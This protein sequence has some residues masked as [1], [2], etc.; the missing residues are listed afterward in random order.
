MRHGRKD[1]CP[2]PGPR[3]SLSLCEQGRRVRKQRRL[4]PAVDKCR[5][6]RFARRNLG[7]LQVPSAT[8][9]FNDRHSL[10]TAQRERHANRSFAVPNS[11]FSGPAGIVSRFREALIRARSRLFALWTRAAVTTMRLI[12]GRSWRAPQS[13]L[14]S[15]W[16]SSQ[17]YPD[18]GC[19]RSP[20]SF[21]EIR[22]TSGDTFAA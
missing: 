20:Q 2:G 15:G 17:L 5:K 18:R 16:A 19:I 10:T 13:E 9:V 1:L 6:N 11:A 8:H 4:A 7:R 22:Q 14:Q 12:L 3:Q 21:H